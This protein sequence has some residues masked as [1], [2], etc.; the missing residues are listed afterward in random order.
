MVSK[1][2]GAEHDENTDGSLSDEGGF[3][4]LHSAFS[5][6]DWNKLPTKLA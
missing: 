5:S 4:R 6:L 1:A 2:A 3:A